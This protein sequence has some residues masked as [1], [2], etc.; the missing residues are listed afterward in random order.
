MTRATISTGS[1][2]F[3]ISEDDQPSAAIVNRGDSFH[4]VILADFSGRDH[5]GPGDSLST[6]KII[7]IDRDNFDDVFAQLKVQCDLPLA[8]EPIVFGELDDMHPDFIFQRV[9]LFEKFR[10]LK[11]KLKSQSTFAEAAAKIDAWGTVKSSAPTSSGLDDRAASS[12]AG[13]LLDDLLAAEAPA[14]AAKS[15]NVQALLKD[16]ATPYLSPKPD[17][18]LEDYIQ[19]V[20][21]ASSS[22]MR[23]LLHHH[24]FQALESAWRSLYLLVRRLETDAQLKLFIVDAS[25]Q[26]LLEDTTKHEGYKDCEL[27]KLLVENRQ[28]AGVAAFSVIMADAIF[29]PKEADLKALAKLG[30][31]AQA[32]DA[33][34]IAG[35]S[36]RLAGCRSLA[37]T[38][39]H[40]DWDFVLS[41]AIQEQWQELR[42]TPQARHISLVA[43]RFL[44]R[45]PYGLK[46]S[47]IDSFAF[48]E[49]PPGDRHSYYLWSCGAWL[50]ALLLAENYSNTGQGSRLW[51][52]NRRSATACLP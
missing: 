9:P 45:M 22:L 39:L 34:F 50:L 37:Q 11:R 46:T 38:P 42:A 18:K 2:P 44:T 24:R 21:E 28:A 3:K 10:Q 23:K 13:S 17:P 49:L 30:D 29:G 6:R 31:V 8:D 19:T 48:E 35:G 41:A 52:R 20:D 47:P 27:Y 4:I 7:A 1:M 5:S 36:E 33:A 25:Q 43:P 51:Q 26:A 12:A 40:D 14:Q 15:F 32:I 16:I